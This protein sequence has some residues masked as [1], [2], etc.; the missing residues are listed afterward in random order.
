MGWENFQYNTYLALVCVFVCHS[1]ELTFQ[2][3]NCHLPFVGP[4]DK[5]V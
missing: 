1:Q 5:Y 4:L 2:D 3:V